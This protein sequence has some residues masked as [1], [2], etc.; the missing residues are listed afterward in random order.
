LDEEMLSV[1]SSN[2]KKYYRY[3][4]DVKLFTGNKSEA[5]KALVTLERVLRE[6]NLHTQSAKTKIERS[7]SI[8][9]Q[10]V[11]SWVELMSDENDDKHENAQR[12]FNNVFDVENIDDWQR[13]YLRCLT[14]MREL[15]QALNTALNLFWKSVTP[16]NG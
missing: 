6:L 2:T 13:A 3:V 10:D 4:D 7:D 5:Q 8:F 11:E 12:F 14:V 16:L 15:E 9:N 1:V